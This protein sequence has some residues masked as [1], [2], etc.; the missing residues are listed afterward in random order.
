MEGVENFYCAGEEIVDLV[1]PEGVTKINDGAFRGLN[2][3]SIRIADSVEYVGSYAFFNYDTEAQ[4]I[5]IGKNVTTLGENFSALT[6]K[7]TVSTGNDNFFVIDDVLYTDYGYELVAY[8][9]AKSDSIFTI[10]KNVRTIRAYAFNGAYNLRLI[11]G[12]TSN[13]YYESNYGTK[14]AEDILDLLLDG[15]ELYR[16]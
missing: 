15:W 14:P 2:F 5:Y 3:N 7:Y 9:G 6:K 12:N 16:R 10:S 4:E 11:Q 8:P 1:I 13:W